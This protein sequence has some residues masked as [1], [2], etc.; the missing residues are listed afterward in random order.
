MPDKT[1]AF[2]HA[3]PLL[4]QPGACSYLPSS[5]SEVKNISQ[6]FPRNSRS[7]SPKTAVS[8][9]A[10]ELYSVGE[11]SAVLGTEYPHTK[12]RISP[13]TQR[14]VSRSVDIVTAFSSQKKS[15]QFDTRL[16]SGFTNCINTGKWY[17]VYLRL[18]ASS[19]VVKYCLY[20]S[21]NCI[22]VFSQVTWNR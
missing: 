18:V 9:R 6:R 7:P 10:D 21:A 12:L 13:Y 1:W 3:H 15:N 20:P 2:L 5:T 4:H 14:P 22:T 11:S 17:N 16:E 8:R 19:L